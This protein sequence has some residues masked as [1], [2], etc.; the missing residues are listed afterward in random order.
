MVGRHSVSAYQVTANI[1]H[2][3]WDLVK[4]T[5]TLVISCLVS[6][7]TINLNFNLKVWTWEILPCLKPRW[8]GLD[9][10]SLK[11][12][13]WQTV[14]KGLTHSAWALNHCIQHNRPFSRLP[15]KSKIFFSRKLIVS[16]S[17]Y[18]S[19][20]PKITKNN[21]THFIFTSDFVCSA[22]AW[23]PFDLSNPARCS[24]NILPKARRWAAPMSQN[25]CSK[26]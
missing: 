15:C 4:L 1:F 23:F 13:C 3:V 25:T 8:N 16:K 9:A 10:I 14:G 21:L 18:A 22:S 12:L 7:L 20:R 19:Q 24:P 6:S 11:S 26:H 5:K 17:K 2:G